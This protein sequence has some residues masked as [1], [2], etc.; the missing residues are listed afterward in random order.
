R[1]GPA[2]G[3]AAEPGDVR[4]SAGRRRSFGGGRARRENG[5]RHRI[6][7]AGEAANRGKPKRPFWGGR[8]WIPYLAGGP[9][10]ICHLAGV[11]AVR[12][13]G[14]TG[15]VPPPLLIRVFSCP[16]SVTAGPLRRQRPRRG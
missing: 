6:T 11:A 12:L 14:F 5:G 8:V 10:R 13:S 15:P 1:R 3:R 4:G 9:A 2:A 7:P 16:R